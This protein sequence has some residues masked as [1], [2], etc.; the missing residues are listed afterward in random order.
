[1]WNFLNFSSIN[2]NWLKYD[3]FHWWYHDWDALLE[4]SACI[5]Q[6]QERILTLEKSLNHVVQEFE[7]EHTS[8]V[9]KSSIENRSSQNEIEK[10]QRTIELRTKEM[11]RVKKLA[12]N[13][14]EQRTEIEQFFLESLAHVKKEIVANRLEIWMNKSA[15]FLYFMLAGA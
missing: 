9:T 14:L 13:I 7:T 1:M 6:L 3:C 10:L 4:V 15:V 8:L 12:R 11:N 2:I 5:F